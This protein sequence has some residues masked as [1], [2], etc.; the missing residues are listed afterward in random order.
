MPTFEEFDKR[1][2]NLEKLKTEAWQK[3][4]EEHPNDPQAQAL[5][6]SRLNALDEAAYGPG[7]TT[8]SPVKIGALGIAAESGAD[9]LEQL[10][11]GD[12][13][14]GYDDNVSYQRLIAVAQLYFLAHVEKAG[15][16][17]SVAKLVELFNAGEVRL[18]DG[19]GAQLLYQIDRTR[20]TRYSAHDRM[21]AYSRV[22]GY[23]RQT[24]PAGARPNTAFRKLF[25]TFIRSVAKF[26]RDRR[27]SDVIR[28]DS[29]RGN[30]GSIAVVR[31]AGIEL[32][33]N[34]KSASYGYVNVLRQEVFQL[35][36]T[37]V[38][39]LSAPDVQNLFGTEEV[40]E[41]MEQVLR[42]HLKEEVRVSERLRL[43]EA[44]ENVLHWLAAPHVTVRDRSVFEASLDDISEDAEEWLTVAASLGEFGAVPAAPRAKPSGNVVPMQRRAV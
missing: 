33:N 44:G 22:F 41:T 11:A 40:W 25:V 28:P 24:P 37:C 34:L 29:Q 21:Q 12:R 36:A 42:Q 10:P 9:R 1:R 2:R 15:L 7:R 13:P 14:P 19:P 4:A 39:I 35:Q 30:F 38:D 31:R 27:V 6:M 32:R 16:F 17:R 5:L 26:Y 3:L 23:T 20:L 8:L 18:S 43:A